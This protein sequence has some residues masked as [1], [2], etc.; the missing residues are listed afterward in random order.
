MAR[1]RPRAWAWITAPALAGALGGLLY[2][3]PP[4]AC[5]L[6]AGLT[7]FAQA[8]FLLSGRYRRAAAWLPAGDIGATL[9]WT[10]SARLI[11]AT[12]PGAPQHRLLEGGLRIAAAMAVS[13]S[14]L[15]A[16]TALAMRKLELQPIR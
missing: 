13:W 10:A 11:V 4:G 6:S 3:E 8:S 12:Q 2:P 16:G 9:S 1:D 14:G 5:F 15:A 7:G